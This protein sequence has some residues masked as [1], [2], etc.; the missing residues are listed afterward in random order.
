MPTITSALVRDWMS[1]AETKRDVQRIQCVALHS[2]QKYSSKT[3]API[4]CVSPVTV[5]RV[6]VAYAKEGENA[7]FHEKRGGRHHGYLSIEEEKRLLQPFLQKAKSGGM[8]N[9]KPVHQAL[10]KRLKKTLPLTTTYKMLHRQGW[11]KL[12]PRPYHPNGEPIAREKFKASFPPDRGTSET[13][14]HP[15]GPDAQDTL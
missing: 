6:W 8:I 10:E 15:Q 14:S 12:T 2:L 11:R 4:V 13:R 1:R 9:I 7:L 3:I 5:R